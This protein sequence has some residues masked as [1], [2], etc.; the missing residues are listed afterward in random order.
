M[1]EVTPAMAERS[2]AIFGR[3]L[4]PAEAVAR[5][6]ADV[7][8]SGDAAL[9]D[10][11]RRIDGADIEAFLVPPVEMEAARRSLAPDLWEALEVAARRIRT[12]HEKEHHD[13]WIAW[14][15]E[16]TALGQ[17]VRPLERVG[18]YAPGGTAAYP[19]TVLMTAIPARVAGVS[20]IVLC[21]PPRKGGLADPAILAAA[22]I[23]GVDQVFRVGGAQAI[24]AM[25]YG[26]ESIPRV[27]KILGPG[28]LF[29]SLAKRA[30]AASVAIDQI[31]GP[32]ETMILADDSSDADLVAA[33]LLAQSE[34]D[35]LSSAILLTNSPRLAAEVQ[36]AAEEQLAC[37]QRREIAAQA[38]V[39][40]GAIILVQSLEQAMALANEYAPEHLCLLVRDPWAWVGRV[41]NAGGIFVGEQST[42]A[43]GDYVAGPSHVMP[44]GGT[45]RFA[46][47]LH[48]GDFLKVISLFGL[49]AKTAAALIPAATALARAEGLT[50]HAAAACARVERD[51]TVGVTPGRGSP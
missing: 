16:G 26:T 32:T 51:G 24:A 40:Q 14:E 17:I 20:H 47:P 45:A 35:A 8:S 6:L 5:I 46:S 31:A 29:V 30:V 3:P 49:D 34:H 23:A 13:S 48:V 27:D 21:T 7:H 19:S 41:R 38:L 25:A 18:L 15:G 22:G 9:R 36:A 43:L 37:L 12:F 2:A 50:G 28:N 33:D 4:A 42:E 39:G 1:V 44:T 11:S 10:Y